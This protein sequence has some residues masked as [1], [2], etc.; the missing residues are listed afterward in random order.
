MIKDQSCCSHLQWM[1]VVFFSPQSLMSQ[2]ML[3][4]HPTW[5]VLPCFM[6]IIFLP[7]AFHLFLCSPM[8]ASKVENILPAK[9]AE[10]SEATPEGLSWHRAGIDFVFSAGTEPQPRSLPGIPLGFVAT[11]ANGPPSRS[12]RSHPSPP[13]FFSPVVPN[14]DGGLYP[15]IGP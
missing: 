10:K 6:A 3:G 11:R 12:C 4:D 9:L 7:I 15:Q 13:S 5:Q 2:V 14:T 8:P 1:T